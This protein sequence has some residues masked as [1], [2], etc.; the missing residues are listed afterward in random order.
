M[1]VLSTRFSSYFLKK[2]I[3][4]QFSQTA[5]KIVKENKMTDAQIKTIVGHGP[6]G[7]VMKSDVLEVLHNIPAEKR[8]HHGGSIHVAQPGGASA[9]APKKA[10]PPKAPSVKDSNAPFIDIPLTNM[11]KVL[12]FLWNFLLFS[13]FYQKIIGFFRLLP[14]DFLKPKTP[15]LISIWLN[16]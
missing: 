15:F 10:E 6:R 11:R 12:I 14:Q 13:F 16:T 8:F 3:A 7:L 1:A 5:D 9:A 2:T 4:L